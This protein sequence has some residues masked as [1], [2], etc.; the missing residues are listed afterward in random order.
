M[1]KDEHVDESRW[2]DS[3][4]GRGRQ[5]CGEKQEIFEISEATWRDS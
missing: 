3:E 1:T 4:E 5:E 2:V